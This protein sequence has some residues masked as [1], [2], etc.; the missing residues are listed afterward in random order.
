MNDIHVN[1]KKVT[2]GLPREKRYAEDRA[3]T[4]EEIR[5]LIEYP[6]RRIKA[7]RFND[8]LIRYQVGSMG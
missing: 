4:I 1:W 5:R 3:P 8:D 7:H 6:D 2:T